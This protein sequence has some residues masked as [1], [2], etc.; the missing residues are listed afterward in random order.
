MATRLEMVS[1]TIPLTFAAKLMFDKHITGLPVT[2]ELGEL[3]GVISW[4]DVLAA[5]KE[6]ADD[7]DY[8]SVSGLMT[9]ASSSA[10][11]KLQG[12][13]ADHMS[14]ELVTVE[15]SATVGAA[16]KKMADQNVHRV[17]V[18][19]EAGNLAGLVSAIDVVRHVVA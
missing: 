11:E 12:T 5:M 8:F 17:L 4:R 6:P 15:N 19:D 1:D 3:V 14:R 13:V 2:T 18:V 9:A 7:S 16:A 10:L